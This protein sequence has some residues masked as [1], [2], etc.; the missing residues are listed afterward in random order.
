M[1]ATE[2]QVLANRKNGALSRGPKTAAGKN[3]SKY[4]AIK[5]GFA[6]KTIVDQTKVQEIEKLARVL[7]QRLPPNVA[8]AFAQAEIE[9][10]CVRRYQVDLEASLASAVDAGIFGI[11][12]STEISK[13]SD[14]IDKL[15]KSDRYER[16]AYARQRRALQKNKETR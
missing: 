15:V 10:Q 5:H 14:I 16:R 13:T 3:R 1:M 12:E 7:E 6:S 2:K 9:R 8:Y 11:M 4:N